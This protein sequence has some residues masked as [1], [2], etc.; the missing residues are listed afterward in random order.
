MAIFLKDQDVSSLINMDSMITSI[1]NMF[2]QHGNGNSINMPRKHII[3]PHSEL[4][5]MGGWLVYENVFGVKAYTISKTGYSFH[6]LL[7]NAINGELLAFIEANRLGQLRTGATTAVAAKYLASN[8]AS[9]VG[10]IGTGFQ[11]MSQI[12]AVSKIRDIREF[13]VYSRN[14]R[15]RVDF[16]NDA[17]RSLSLPVVPVDSN[18]FAVQNSDIVICI[19]SNTTPVVQGSWLDTETLIIAAGPASAHIQ[20]LDEA[21]IK[22]V[23]HFVVDS[24]AQAPYEAGDIN[25]S[26]DKGLLHWDQVSELSTLVSSKHISK[27]MAGSI[28]VK[29]M[30]IGLADVAAAKLVYDTAKERDTGDLIML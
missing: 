22:L 3:G 19:A 5:V 23:S 21:A 8:T 11:A 30:G 27:R 12:E 25:I 24:L 20:E 6:I 7:Y 26:V 13:K 17:S 18:E 10:I 4:A 15:K 29:L 16:A 1:E 2:I 9:T 14:N 28:Y